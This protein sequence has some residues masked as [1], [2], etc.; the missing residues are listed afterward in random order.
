TCG[1]ACASPVQT[2]GQEV[3]ADGAAEHAGMHVQVLMK[4]EASEQRLRSVHGPRLLHLATHGFFRGARPSADL[5]LPGLLPKG[6]KSSQEA[7]GVKELDKL[8]ALQLIEELI[9]KTG[10][11]TNGRRS[12]WQ[13]RQPART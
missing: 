9:E 10:R 2:A 6:F 8:H 13:G 3:R 7:V 1:N 12:P 4:A 11:K 5:G